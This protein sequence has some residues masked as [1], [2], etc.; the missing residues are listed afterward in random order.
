MKYKIILFATALYLTYGCNQ[1]GEI[2]SYI[3]VDTIKVE[4]DYDTQGTASHNITDSWVFVNNKLVGMFEAPF[5]IPVLNSGKQTIV[6]EP[7]IRSSGSDSKREIYNVMQ[8][9]T[10]DTVLKQGEIITIQPKYRYKQANFVY[11]ENFDE[12]SSL[13]VSKLDYSRQI[14]RIIGEGESFE[15]FSLCFWTDKDHPNFECKTINKYQLPKDRRDIYVEINFKCDNIFNFGFFSIEN[16]GESKKSVYYFKPTN[17]QWKK[18]YINIKDHVM[19]TRATEFRFYFRSVLS[20]TNNE[21]KE[22]VFIDNIKV[23]Y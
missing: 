4:T 3:A 22:K 8:S 23:I 14:D 19:D 13:E 15:S 11:L 17:G 2:P 20:D 6:I 5:Q 12:S 21:E 16:T 9:Y 18:V 10:I 7:G 1:S